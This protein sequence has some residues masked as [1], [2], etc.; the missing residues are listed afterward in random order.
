MKCAIMKCAI[1]K[2][3]LLPMAGWPGMHACP[4]TMPRKHPV[5]LHRHV[6]AYG[7]EEEGA[8]SNTHRI[9]TPHVLAQPVQFVAT[10]GTAAC[11][12]CGGTHALC[13]I[14]CV[15][16]WLPPQLTAGLGVHRGRRSAAETIPH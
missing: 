12:P 15:L 10:I 11:M 4:P 9:R 5:S 8:H 13:A 14:P 16:P 6:L 3:G 2:C 1:M 7:G